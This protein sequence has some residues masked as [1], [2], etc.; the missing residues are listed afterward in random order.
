MVKKGLEIAAMFVSPGRKSFPASYTCNV[1]LS[2]YFLIF[3]H[4]VRHL[5]DQMDKEYNCDI[6]LLVL[7]QVCF[8]PHPT[9]TSMRNA[10]F[11][12]VTQY[13]NNMSFGGIYSSI[14]WNIENELYKINV[15]ST[16]VA[17]TGPTKFDFIGI[18]HQILRIF[19]LLSKTVWIIRLA[20][21]KDNIYSYN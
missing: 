5:N 8:D 19:L 20:L 13:T 4:Y 6:L 11:A 1:V 10:C 9:L 3:F 17:A 7:L 12:L 21:C 16:L 15:H 18:K 2:R 14:P